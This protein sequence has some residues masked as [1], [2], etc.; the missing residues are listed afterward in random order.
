[1]VSISAGHK[2]GHRG[3]RTHNPRIKRPQDHGYCGLSCD[4]ALTAF[5]TGPTIRPWL[6]SF[7]ATNHATPLRTG[8]VHHC[9]TASPQ[10]A[11]A[12]SRALNEFHGVRVG[13]ARSRRPPAAHFDWPMYAAHSSRSP[14]SRV[15]IR[16]V[17]D[18]RR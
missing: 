5:P 6:T 15:Q 10:P 4:Y 7:H 14:Q 11:S 13:E 17:E 9:R 1:M 16:P 2:G 8:A 18:G 3:A 12:V